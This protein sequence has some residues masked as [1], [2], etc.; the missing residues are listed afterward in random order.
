[1][2]R[3]SLVQNI[4]HKLKFH[5]SPIQILTEM[6]LALSDQHNVQHHSLVQSLTPKRSLKSKLERARRFFKRTGHFPDSLPKGPDFKRLVRHPKHAFH[7]GS[8]KL[9]I[10]EAGY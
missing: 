7:S 3:S 2:K 9:E 6:T 4:G 1:M 10:R 8:Q 5:N